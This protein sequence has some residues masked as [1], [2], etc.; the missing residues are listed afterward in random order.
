MLKFNF[1]CNLLVMLGS[2]Y[3]FHS[4]RINFP[5]KFIC[6]IYVFKSVFLWGWNVEF[7]VRKNIFPK[8]REDKN[9]QGTIL[10]SVSK[11][12]SNNSKLILEYIILV[13]SRHLFLGF[14]FSWYLK[15]SESIGK[16]TKREK[17]SRGFCVNHSHAFTKL[18][19]K[20]K[21]TTHLHKHIYALNQ[22]GF[23]FPKTNLKPISLLSLR[24]YFLSKLY[25]RW[26]LF[27][28]QNLS[29]SLL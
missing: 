18:G 17:D 21:S 27:Q 16:G 14:T 8:A 29:P 6:K 13:A 20:S 3:A 26:W 12:E 24:N 23:V 5:K 9:I 28:K 1:W 19:F 22:H 11:W 4:S 7:G 2:L 25:I 10:N 15:L